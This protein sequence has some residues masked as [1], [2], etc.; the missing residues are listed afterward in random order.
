MSK[1]FIENHYKVTH[2]RLIELIQAGIVPNGVAVVRYDYPI[3]AR[4][5]AAAILDDKGILTVGSRHSKKCQQF[6]EFYPYWIRNDHKTYEE[7]IKI[8]EP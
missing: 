6:N 5:F 7:L 2:N 3:D 4:C 8:T 1:Q